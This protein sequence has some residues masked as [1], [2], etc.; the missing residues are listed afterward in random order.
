MVGRT[1][2]GVKQK[3]R[4]V[5]QFEFASVPQVALPRDLCVLH[6]QNA[7]VS[8]YRDLWHRACVEAATQ[9]KSCDARG[10][11]SVRLECDAT[12]RCGVTTLCC[13]VTEN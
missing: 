4:D 9:L 8:E 3:S 6:L 10:F 1:L 5:D 13:G 7:R 12:R 11:R 2:A